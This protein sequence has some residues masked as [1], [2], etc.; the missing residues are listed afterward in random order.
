VIRCSNCQTGSWSLDPLAPLVPAQNLVQMFLDGVGEKKRRCRS[1]SA[2]MAPPTAMF[3][4]RHANIQAALR[5]VG[6][7][8]VHFVATIR[9]ET[10][11]GN[12][13][14]DLVRLV[15]FS[16]HFIV[17]TPPQVSIAPMRTVHIDARSRRGALGFYFLTF[18]HFGARREMTSRL[19]I[20]YCR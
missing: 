2:K 14:L 1:R 13:S 15:F 12:I 18:G 10:R 6:D 5:V 3:K 8:A 9:S 20:R 19:T 17:L 7:S 16:S 11:S 4:S